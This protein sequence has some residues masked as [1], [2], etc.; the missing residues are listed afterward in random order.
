M[1]QLGSQQDKDNNE[2]EGTTV[3]DEEWEHQQPLGWQRRDRGTCRVREKRVI[4]KFRGSLH[5]VGICFCC[6]EAEQ[7]TSLPTEICG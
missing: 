1:D 6:C 2:S 7:N 4:G 5:R 3:W